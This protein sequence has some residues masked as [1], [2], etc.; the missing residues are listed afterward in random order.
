MNE[1]SQKAVYRIRNWREY[2][3]A[4]IKRGSLTVWVDD[5]ALRAWHHQGPPRWGGQVRLQ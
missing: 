1:Q 2:N 5:E 4:L 3:Q